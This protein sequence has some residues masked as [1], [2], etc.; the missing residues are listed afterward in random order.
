MDSET[1]T[2]RSIDSA[3][4]TERPIDSETETERQIYRDRNQRDRR[5]TKR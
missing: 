5:Q 1:E 2:E 3:T 4:E